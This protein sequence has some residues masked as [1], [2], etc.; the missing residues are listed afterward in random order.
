VLLLVICVP[1]VAK[2]RQPASFVLASFNTAHAERVGVSS[3]W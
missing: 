3:P 2:E 1:A